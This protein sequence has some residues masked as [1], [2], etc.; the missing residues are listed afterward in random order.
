M[1]R[2]TVAPL[3]NCYRPSPMGSAANVDGQRARPGNRGL[4]MPA[5]GAQLRRGAASLSRVVRA[6]WPMWLVA[7]SLNGFFVYLALLDAIDVEPVTPLTGAYYGLV[8]AGLLA[9]VWH[10]R[11]ALV[12]RLRP[13]A[14]TVVAFV[15][16]AAVLSSW[17]VLNTALLSDGT[18]AAR[19]AGLLVLW[20]IPT[21]LVAATLRRTDLP[22][23]ARALVALSVVF[24]AIELLALVRAGTDVFRFSPIAELDPITAGLI[25]AIG[26][27]AALSLRPAEMQGKALRF[28]VVVVLAAAA[29]LP[30]SRGPVV[31]LAFGALALA[32]A[33]PLR[34]T[35]AAAVAV[36]GGFALGLLV[37]SH[38]GSFGYLVSTDTSSP[39]DDSTRP[40]EVIEAAGGGISTLSIR[41]QWLE[42]AIRDVPEEP[43]FGHGVGM[44]VD[45][46]PEAIV[47]GVY[48]QR[49]YPH[50]TLVEAAYSLGVIGLVAYL[51][52]IGSAVLALV[53]VVRRSARDEGVV[54]AVAVG[55]FAFVNTNVS[56]EIGEDALLWTAAA[57]AVALYADFRRPTSSST[58][59]A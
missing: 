35:A 41:R 29:V 23:V 59:R 48:G 37:A 15:A 55:A 52:F 8:C 32:V 4:P 56:G 44:Q 36:L 20:S 54:F 13:A 17:F 28:I 34:R 45:R 33:Q 27:I 5:G 43:I 3:D 51:V 53:T 42:D 22:E 31:A 14:P 10:R 11:G 2:R 50:N 7:F 38:I 21:A 49:T 16:A 25:P 26:A 6:S 30:G 58:R 46:T 39:F 1:V 9:T 18:F 47:M 57:V 24:V 40:Q 19:L 12:A